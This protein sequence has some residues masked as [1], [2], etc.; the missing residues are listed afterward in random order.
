MSP[1]WN[2]IRRDLFHHRSRTLLVVLS[3]AIGVFAFG[4]IMAGRVKIEAELQQSFRATNPASAS[5][6]T[7]PFDDE[8]VAAVRQL[9]GVSA[10]EGKR[11]V[12]ARIKLG[13]DDWQDALLHVLPDDGITS[14]NIVRP[15]QGTWP[16]PKRS[17]LIERSSFARLDAP[18]GATAMVTLAGET[19]RPL[20]VVGLSHDL[21]LPPA[22]IAGQVFG[23]ITFDT[24]TWLG[25][26]QGYNQLAIVVDEPLRYDEAQ[27]RMVSD[28]VERLVQ[29]GGRPIL[30]S[31]VP[32]PLQ[33]PAEIILPTMFAIMTTIGTLALLIST[34]L[35]INTMSAILIQQTRQIGVMKAIGARNDQLALLYLALAAA[36][37][38]LALL[39]AAPL[40]MLGANLFAW[41][42][43][44]QMNLD[45]P[46]FLIVPE[47]ILIEALVAMLVPMLAALFPILSV[48]RRPTHQALAGA[49]ATPVV[50]GWLDRLLS[51]SSLLSRPARLA[52]R[53]TF[54]RKGRLVRTL[55]ALSLGGAV[56]LAAMSL[57]ESLYTTL[58]ASVASQRYDVEI[59][60][61][62]S[63][64]S[65]QVMP[66][67][68]GT[69]GVSSVEPLLRNH[70][71]PV[72]SDGTTG[73]VMSVRALPVTSAMLAP[74]MVAGR[75]FVPGDERAV[76]LSTNI[77]QKEPA[78]NVGTMI[79]LKLGSREEQW[80]VIGLIEELMPPINP[81]LVYMPLDAYTR[82]YGGFGRSDT[83]RVATTQSD[84]ASHAAAVIKLEQHLS[85][86]GYQLHSIHS[87]SDDRMLLAERFDL[88][89]VILSIMAT[90]IS[91][92]GGLGLAGTMSIN[93]I[94]RT[95]EIGIMRA[96]GASDH[97]LAQI[98]VSESLTIALLAWLIGTL[99]SIPLSYAMGHVFG[100]N[101]LN[102]PLIWSY[103]IPA[104]LVWLI[105]VLVI[106]I[107][108]SL[109]SARTAVSLTVREVLAYE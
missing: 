60:L 59:Q 98:I 89:G 33:H 86:A 88:I 66:V 8:L 61:N 51:R 52:L 37:G 79:T 71:F 107:I 104:V 93:V 6:T 34:F 36:F 21:S 42:I 100:L 97:A 24:L 23:Y 54:R 47:V 53:N 49:T 22:P 14:I 63:Y 80:R 106:A 45:L 96:I 38:L 99:I 3:I 67:V 55:V 16:P 70:A 2:K 76:V 94:E 87:R 30:S 1:R 73:E 20:P 9:P 39:L 15:W 13:S 103:T 29:R 50:Q 43:A 65:D 72:R 95:R 32:P 19:V 57:R 17:M 28:R 62:R 64:R 26:P 58:D 74:R 40:S 12:A 11:V 109:L 105:A 25:G 101:L 77:L 91:V 27:I 31:E 75:W 10:A 78:I 48:L 83:L 56:F 7:L 44:D 69:P 41:F 68:L 108:A 84:A 90:I 81:V 92:V 46:P 85:Q 18:L 82:T 35:I 4:T 5:I 102:S